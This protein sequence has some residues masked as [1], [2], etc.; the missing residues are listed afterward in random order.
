MHFEGEEYDLLTFLPEGQKKPSPNL[1]EYLFNYSFLL[2][3]GSTA[4]L[5]SWQESLL[6]PA[7]VTHVTLAFY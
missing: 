1:C 7:N 5:Q 6:L 4:D 3:S 2:E